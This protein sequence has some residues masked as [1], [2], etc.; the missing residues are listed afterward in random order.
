MVITR[1]DPSLPRTLVEEVVEGGL[2]RFKLYERDVNVRER[3][4]VWTPGLH[5]RIALV[6]TSAGN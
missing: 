6:V 5:A 3:A 1:L 2:R 4:N